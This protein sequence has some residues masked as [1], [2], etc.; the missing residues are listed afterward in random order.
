M[1]DRIHY[2]FGRFIGEFDRFIGKIGRLGISLFQNLF[3]LIDYI[4]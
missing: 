3:Q 1:F 4:I 2:S